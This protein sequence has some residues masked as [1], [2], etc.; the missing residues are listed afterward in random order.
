MTFGFW[1]YGVKIE[2]GFLII[3]NILSKKQI[4]IEEIKSIDF[5][6]MNLTRRT[7]YFIKFIDINKKSYLLSY[8]LLEGRRSQELL[9]DLLNDNSK[10]FISQKIHRLLEKKIPDI[11]LRF[12]FKVYKGQF[13]KKDSELS[14]HYPSCDFFVG[15][16]VTIIILLIP[17]IFM[18]IGG[19][20]FSSSFGSQDEFVQLALWIFGGFMFS[21]S[22]VNIFL[23]LISMYRGHKFTFMTMIIGITSILIDILK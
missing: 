13:F 6:Q 14:M 21:L 15:I 5:D 10:I 18:L 2:N 8:S 4:K 11:K 7:A 22:L 23:A 20:L 17:L 16:G 1:K 19:T 9:K 3:C 12:D